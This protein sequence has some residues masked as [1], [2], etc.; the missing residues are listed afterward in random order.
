MQK[1]KRKIVRYTERENKL[2][3]LLK[4]QRR[5][6]TTIEISRM[7]YGREAPFNSRQSMLQVLRQLNL[8]LKENREKVRIASSERKGPYPIDFWLEEKRA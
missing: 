2:L 6:L 5:P 3:K 4:A 8:K 7:F 1:P